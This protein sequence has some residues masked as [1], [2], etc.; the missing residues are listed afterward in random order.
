[1]IARTARHPVQWSERPAR[2]GCRGTDEPDNPTTRRAARTRG[3]TA[4]GI[5]TLVVLRCEAAGKG[6]ISGRLEVDHFRRHTLLYKSTQQRLLSGLSNPPA[7]G[8]ATP[9]RS[10]N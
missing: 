5:L 1:M 10:T 8:L 2:R 3:I 4:V 9:G 7:P 6:R